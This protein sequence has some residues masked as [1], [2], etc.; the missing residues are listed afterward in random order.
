MPTTEIWEALNNTDKY[1]WQWT[2][3]DGYIGYKVI[4][5]TDN[6]KT[7]FLPAA[8]YVLGTSFNNV[9]SRGEYWSGTADT[10]TSACDLSFKSDDVND[11]SLGSGRFCGYS[12]RPVRLVAAN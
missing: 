2:T 10:S 11:K 5:K 4:S 8:G 7:I 9:G 1:E 12:V 3:Q 6:T